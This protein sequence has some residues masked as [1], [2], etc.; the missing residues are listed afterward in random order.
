MITQTEISAADDSEM[1]YDS[2]K[3]AK[4]EMYTPTI[5]DSDEEDMYQGIGGSQALLVAPT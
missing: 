3:N 5:S 2:K 1:L 4:R